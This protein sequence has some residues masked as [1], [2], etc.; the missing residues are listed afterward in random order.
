MSNLGYYDVKLCNCAACG[1]EILG[2][3]MPP[4]KELPQS[5]RDYYYV[6]GR[7]NERPYCPSCFRIKQHMSE[8][9]KAIV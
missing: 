7:I 8:Q 2:E 9:Q 1:Q 5:F 4:H 3:S 6:A